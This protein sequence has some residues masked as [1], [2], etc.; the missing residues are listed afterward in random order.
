MMKFTF[1]TVV[2]LTLPC[3]LGVSTHGD[4]STTWAKKYGSQYDLLFSG[5]LSFSHLPYAKCLEQEESIF[6]I[7]ILGIPFD[8]SV[9]YRPGFV[10]SQIP[11]PREDS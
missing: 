11:H 8:T 9:S 5:P 2:G 7:A 10:Q 3:V 1:G 6:D 4:E